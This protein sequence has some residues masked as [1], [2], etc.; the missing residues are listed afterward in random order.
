MGAESAAA[1][2]ETHP[3][4]WAALAVCTVLIGIVSVVWHTFSLFLVALTGSFGWS[5]AETSLGF[6]IFVIVSG[7]TGPNTGQLIARYG[8]RRVVTIGGLVLAT[9]LVATSRMQTLWQFYLF[10]GVIGGVG[11]N[12]AGWVPVVTL[13]QTWF[14]ERLGMATGIASAGVGVG[15]MV[16]VP[17]I[18]ESILQFGWR[19]TYLLTAVV[20]LMAV[21]PAAAFIREGPLGRRRGAGLPGASRPEDEPGVVDRDWVRRPWS[22]A[23][24]LHTR[25]FW[26]LLVAFFL[27]SFSSQQ[28]LA[29]HVAYLRGTGVGALAAASIVGVIGV[30]SVPARISWGAASDRIGR[31][32]TYTLAAAMLV[33]AIA[34]LWLVSVVPGGA[35]LAY[36][37]AVLMGVGY[38]SS[39]TMPP[40]L[41][42]DMFRGAAYAAIFGGIQLASNGGT[43]VGAFSAGFIYDHTGSYDLAFAIAIAGVFVSAACVWLAAPRLVRRAVRRPA[44]VALSADASPGSVSQP[45]VGAGRER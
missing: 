30:T 38:V 32:L 42:A 36:L 18:Q 17:A 41:T 4:R 12:M 37:Y 1:T 43:G 11:F 20:M 8:A 44:P 5:R 40:I 29:H 14:R 34:V 45:G 27:A 25:R 21:L 35:W 13:L 6:T 3:Y 31:E 22:L 19:V 23:L 10:F 24:A 39:S 15:I 16:L 26:Y 28:I 9:G 7:I 2:A 33:A